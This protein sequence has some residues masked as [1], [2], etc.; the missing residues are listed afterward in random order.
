MPGPRRPGPSHQVPAWLGVMPW[1]TLGM[2][3]SS[4]PARGK[5]FVYLVAPT[6]N[7]C[8]WSQNSEQLLVPPPWPVTMTQSSTFLAAAGMGTAT[9]IRPT[10]YMPP[11]SPPEKREG[12]CEG[13]IPLA[14][15]ERRSE[16]DAAVGWVFHEGAKDQRKS[17]I[18]PE[19]RRG[20]ISEMSST[21]WVSR[22]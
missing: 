11:K 10:L 13:G 15:F 1:A 4:V 7:S 12:A 14:L 5:S 17:C 9:G 21:Q 2:H 6:V 16:R 3:L 19:E 20:S 18:P 8:W 22:W